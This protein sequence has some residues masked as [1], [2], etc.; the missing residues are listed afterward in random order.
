MRRFGALV[1]CL[2]T[3][4]HEATA[5]SNSM[6]CR[7]TQQDTI[8]EVLTAVFEFRKPT[9]KQTGTLYNQQDMKE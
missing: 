3:L 8:V 2:N 4:A 6:L 9:L 7:H 1:E 5:Y